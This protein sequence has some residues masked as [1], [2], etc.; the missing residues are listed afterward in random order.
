MET[1]I[2]YNYNYLSF[3]RDDDGSVLTG[4]WVKN[5]ITNINNNHD[6]VAITPTISIEEALE[7][8]KNGNYYTTTPSGKFPGEEAVAKVEIVYSESIYCNY[9][10]PLYKFYVE[11]PYDIEDHNS[12]GSD[13]IKTFGAYYV[14]APIDGSII[15][16]LVTDSDY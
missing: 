3:I 6:L 10:V 8:L 14:P 9:Y 4:F 12:D 2:N 15:I 11:L 7:E 13:G 1:I 16:N 5:I